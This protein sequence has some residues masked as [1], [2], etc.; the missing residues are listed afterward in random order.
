V[1]N[2]NTFSDG[3]KARTL[4]DSI[5]P[6]LERG[7]AIHALHSILKNYHEKYPE[8]NVLK[9]WVID[10]ATGAE[11][12]FQTYGVPVCHIIFHTLWL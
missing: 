6:I 10:V 1:N 11:K 4:G 5:I 12:A 3:R 7:K 2:W 9:K 8:N